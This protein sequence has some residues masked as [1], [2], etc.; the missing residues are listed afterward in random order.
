MCQVSHEAFIKFS[1]KPYCEPAWRV[2]LNIARLGDELTVVYPFLLQRAATC[3]PLTSSKGSFLFTD[4]YLGPDSPSFS[5][6]SGPRAS[7]PVK[8]PRH[9][10][11]CY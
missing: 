1:C 7:A 9:N 5:Y 2:D 3:C 4:V 6:S 11:R 8:T 10:Y